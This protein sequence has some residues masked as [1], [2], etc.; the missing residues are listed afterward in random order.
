MIVKGHDFPNVTLVGIL[1][2]DLSLSMSDYRASEKTFQL[3]TQA[4]GRAGRGTKEGEVVIQTYQP[5]HYA[6]QYAAKQDYVGF[7]QEEI[8]YR[9]LMNYPPV[10][11][12]LAIHFQS[13]Y[14]NAC[15]EY[16]EFI[17]QEIRKEKGFTQIIGP[18]P[19]R[20]GKINNIFRFILYV[21]C[22][23]Y[24]TLIEMKDRMESIIKQNSKKEV[25]I[26]FDFDRMNSV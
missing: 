12:M 19:A 2:A 24:D 18:A 15:L 7:Y 22:N 16:A 5:D 1:A 8:L 13:I 11:H 17:A 14:E 25:I 9:E 26:Q 21:K 3:L 20:I 4:A 6:I 23:N 10:A